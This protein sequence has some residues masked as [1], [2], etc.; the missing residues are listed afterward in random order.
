MFNLEAAQFAVLSQQT[1]YAYF[2][3]LEVTM[4]SMGQ[5][6]RRQRI[7]YIFLCTS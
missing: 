3:V 2:V 6:Y 5:Y 1:N 4:Y 7:L